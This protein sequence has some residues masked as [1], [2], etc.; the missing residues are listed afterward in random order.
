[1]KHLL[2]SMH[3]VDRTRVL[4]I[5]PSSNSIAWTLI[6]GGRPVLWGKMIFYRKSNIYDK[7]R[8]LSRMMEEIIEA[9]DPTYACVEQM[10]SV[11]NPQTTRVLSYIAGAVGYELANRGIPMEDVPPMVW[12]SYHGYQRILKAMNIPKKEADILRKSQISDKIA[13][14]YPYFKYSDYD[15]S[16]SCAIALWG[17]NISLKEIQIER[18]PKMQTVKRSYKR[19]L[20]SE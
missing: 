3:K 16:D 5:D 17:A 14:V 15:V 6:E 9:T 7:F 12:K 19:K 20:S 4:G 8:M 18:M 13:V 11:Q 2:D 10:I 1:M